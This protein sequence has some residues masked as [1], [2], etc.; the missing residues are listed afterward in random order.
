[1][2]DKVKKFSKKK[3]AFDIWWSALPLDIRQNNDLA[4]ARR[5]FRASHVVGAKPGKTKYTFRAGRL[6]VSVW[7]TNSGEAVKEAA[8][9]L[10]DRIAK[11][12]KRPPA[13][14]WRLTPVSDA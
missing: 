10:D 14:G 8:V 11:P 9:E 4:F 1:M 13:S 7:A 5:C 3:T 12:E 2:L 6:V